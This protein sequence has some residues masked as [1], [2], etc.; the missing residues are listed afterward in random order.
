MK[1]TYNLV[2]AVK[3]WKASTGMISI[4]LLSIYL[5]TKVRTYNK[6]FRLD[7]GNNSCI[8]PSIVFSSQGFASC[9]SRSPFWCHIITLLEEYLCKRKM[10]S[11]N[12]YLKGLVSTLAKLLN[13][14]A[15]TNFKFESQHNNIRATFKS[16][17][18]LFF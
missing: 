16:S 2:R 7:T 15:L 11:G 9:N 4:K 8:S 18:L 3:P 17:L 1:K 14:P 13:T 6:Q 10:S 5:R 12:C